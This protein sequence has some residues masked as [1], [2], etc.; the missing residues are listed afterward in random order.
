LR[1]LVGPDQDG[2]GTSAIA[3]VFGVFTA[4][5]SSG[6]SWHGHPLFVGERRVVQ[7]FW[8]R[9]EAA[10]ERKAQEHGR[11]SLWRMLRRRFDPETG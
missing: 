8:V 11:Q 9:D 6:T 10:A 7:V 1:Y 5:A 4:F 3:P 2:L